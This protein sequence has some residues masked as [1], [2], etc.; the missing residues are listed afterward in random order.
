MA[1]VLTIIHCT[2]CVAR[3]GRSEDEI[4]SGE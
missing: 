3:I 1:P 2:T 4:W